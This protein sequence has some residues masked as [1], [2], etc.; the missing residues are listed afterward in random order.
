MVRL[1]L[2][3]F[4]LISFNLKSQITPSQTSYNQNIIWE[5]VFTDGPPGKVNRGVVE[6]D[7]NCAVVFMPDNMARVHKIDGYSG[8][9]I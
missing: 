4:F 2:P 9:L 5:S 6:S 7:G 1:I 8:E 3:I